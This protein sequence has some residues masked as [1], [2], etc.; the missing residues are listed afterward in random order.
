M[1][2][3]IAKVID[4]AFERVR[5]IVAGSRDD[6]IFS[7]EV[8]EHQLQILL[9]DDICSR[10][11]DNIL[12]FCPRLVSFAIFEL[13]LEEDALELTTAVGNSSIQ[14]FDMKFG[15]P[16]HSADVLGLQ[17][18]LC[19]S[20]DLYYSLEHADLI[21]LLNN[22]PELKMLSLRGPC[23]TE[24]SLLYIMEKCKKLEELVFDNV[25]VCYPYVRS[26]VKTKDST[27]TEG[28]IKLHRPNLK[29]NLLLRP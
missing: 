21:T 7:T 24:L 26:T 27:L 10:E 4:E 20:L 23:W 12:Q 8:S 29:L 9:V 15:N 19:I 5:H 25:N 14:I 2:G 22:N 16:I 6:S 1:S 28:L 17:N 13:S 18:M 3:S 11:L